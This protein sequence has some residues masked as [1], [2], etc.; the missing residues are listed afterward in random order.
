MPETPQNTYSLERMYTVNEAAALLGFPRW[1]LYRAIKNG[2]VPY[3]TLLNSRRLVRLS[4]I[5]AAFQSSGF[6]GGANAE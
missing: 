3:H 6:E 2:L 1:K 5:I 4:E